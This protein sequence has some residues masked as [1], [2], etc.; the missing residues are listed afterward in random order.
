M[1]EPNLLQIYEKVAA[2]RNPAVPA[3]ASEQK[4]GPVNVGTHPAT[5]FE[6]QQAGQQ[7]P[8]DV[9][10]ASDPGTGYVNLDGPKPAGKQGI[11]FVN[12]HSSPDTG[13]R[14]DLGKG[15]MTVTKD[16]SDKTK[17]KPGKGTDYE[18]QKAR[19]HLSRQGVAN[20]NTTTKSAMDKTKVNSKGPDSRMKGRPWLKNQGVG[21][22]NTMTKDATFHDV[23]V[24]SAFLELEESLEG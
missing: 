10:R 8:G 7:K 6:G 9:G 21:G 3:K 20:A 12:R 1:T 16:A 5:Y 14:G 23:G 15:G 13:D 2:E 11:G 22:A 17:V 4:A 18:R 19:A 24:A